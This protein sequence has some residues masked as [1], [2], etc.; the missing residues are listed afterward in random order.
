MRK[1]LLSFI[2]AS[3]LINLPAQSDKDKKAEVV[4]NRLSEKAKTYQTIEASFVFIQNDRTAD[5]KTTQNGKIKVDGEKFA[6]ELGGYEVYNDG[7]ITWSFDEDMNEA[8]RALTADVQDPDSPTFNEMLTLWETGYKY[9]FVEEKTVN[10]VVLQVINLYPDHENEK[11]Y[12]TAKLTI[13]KKKEEIVKI[14]LLGKD[15]ID[16][17][18][19]IKSFKVNLKFPPETFTFNKESHPGCDIIDNVM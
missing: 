2:F 11:S 5:E 3:L 15:G 10:G 18:Y 4:L 17:S 16:Y 19:E 12:H 7:E 6:L 1:I 14:K 8:T 13:D 9:E